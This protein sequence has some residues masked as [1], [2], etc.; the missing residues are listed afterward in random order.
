VIAAFTVHPKSYVYRCT[1]LAP[2]TVCTRLRD[3]IRGAIAFNFPILNDPFTHSDLARWYSEVIFKYDQ[4][5]VYIGPVEEIKETLEGGGS[6]RGEAV[7]SFPTLEFEEICAFSLLLSN[8][9]I[10]GPV[11]ILQPPDISLLP[12]RQNLEQLKREDGSLVLL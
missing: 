6:V 11:V 1:T 7:L 2:S 10:Q 5:N 12:E 8:N 3:A 9:R 4:E